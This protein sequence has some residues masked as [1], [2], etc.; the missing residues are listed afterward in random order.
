MEEHLK[1]TLPPSFSEGNGNNGDEAQRLLPSDIANLL[2]G[3]VAA[4]KSGDKG[5][6]R[7]LF[8]KVTS[9]EPKNE[10]AWLWM[11]S[12]SEQAQERLDYLH[13]VLTINPANERALSWLKLSKEHISR[14][15]IQ[16][17]ADSAKDGN[18]AS[19]IHFLLQAVDYEPDNEIAWMWL[20][21][22]AD[23]PEDKLA[24]LQRILNI[25]P[26]NEQVRE[27]FDTTK[28]QLARSLAQKGIEAANAGNK[29][30]AADILQDVLD[31][32]PNL[33]EVWLLR[34][35]VSDSLEEKESYFKK[36]LDVNPNNLGAVSGLSAIQE[37]LEVKNSWHCVV[38]QVQAKT[39]F[40]ICP[41]CSS[42]L[43]LDDI[44]MLLTKE[45]V[46]E[47]LIREGIQ[48]LKRG[49]KDEITSE[50]YYKL[51]LAYLNLKDLKESIAFFQ[52]ALRL[53]PDDEVLG[54]RID[55]LILRRDKA[56]QDDEPAFFANPELVTLSEPTFDVLDLPESFTPQ[57]EMEIQQSE[58]FITVEE[59][60]EQTEQS[61]MPA[62]PLEA[63]NQHYAPTETTM[64]LETF[65]LP[66]IAVEKTQEAAKEEIHHEATTQTEPEATTETQTEEMMAVVEEV[67][68]QA[69]TVV[70]AADVAE[71]AAEEAHGWPMPEVQM[72]ETAPLSSEFVTN[73]QVVSSEETAQEATPEVSQEM[74]VEAVNETA[75]ETT[76]PEVASEEMAEPVQDVLKV[77]EEVL[78]AAE[79][80]EFTAAEQ[81]Q[82]FEEETEPQQV[83]T[84]VV[85]EAVVEAQQQLPVMETAP[86]TSVEMPAVSEKAEMPVAPQMQQ[87]ESQPQ[88]QPQPVAVKEAPSSEKKSTGKVVMVVDDSP[89]VRKLV[90]LKLEKFGHSVISA[91]DG[92]DALAKMSEETPDLILLD[93]TM[94]RL[95][96]YQLCKLI[97]GNE[98][99]KHVPVV[100][101][102][103]KDGFFDKIRGRMAGASTYLT[104]PFEPEVLLQTVNEH[105]GIKS[106]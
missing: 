49:F 63:L 16:K 28:R 94:P 55:Y 52:A 98:S 103:G 33:E 67:S 58:S 20:A 51:G 14:T 30:A 84:E 17:G 74:P 11:A 13:R 26:T 96:G 71:E 31:Y 102:S 106:N 18:K 88:Q 100:M 12:I 40:D 81:V 82:F 35:Y 68:V 56:K 44:D 80:E 9:F 23:L 34:A 24:Y 41:A 25:N 75:S 2:H 57:A 27:M 15:L 77:K 91:V 8:L 32:D 93:I 62:T 105:C 87:E 47:S 70:E 37:K 64:P 59:V 97:K 83:S 3:G 4:A 95:D 22:L 5:L 85:H 6:A 50:D 19:A 89:T 54:S 72:N 21:S 10:T 1:P 66:E 76:V 42:M 79:L 48:K 38:C 104:K 65:V 61:A 7:T 78:V 45:Y 86:T 39:A 36:V 69:E 53:D 60:Q 101:L 43:N 46:N 99:T 29:K 92:M 73:V 90:S